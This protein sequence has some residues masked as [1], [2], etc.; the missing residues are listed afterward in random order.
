MAGLVERRLEGI[1]SSEEVDLPVEG[2]R[3]Y[4]ILAE[5]RWR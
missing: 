1:S 2:V 4:V 5:E 3:G